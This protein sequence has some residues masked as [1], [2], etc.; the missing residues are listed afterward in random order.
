MKLYKI[1]FVGEGSKESR[2]EFDDHNH[3]EDYLIDTKKK[4]VIVKAKNKDKVRDIIEIT[5]RRTAYCFGL[6]NE[7]Y[8]IKKL[9]S[10]E[11]DDY[12]R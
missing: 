10:N 5:E 9:K 1:K 7:D 6:E 8:F 12:E 2:R 4:S 3:F 11:E